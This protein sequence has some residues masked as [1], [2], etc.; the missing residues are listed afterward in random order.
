MASTP[1]ATR[2][3][4]FYLR[5]R[6]LR[7]C[8]LVLPPPLLL[9]Y[10]PNACVLLVLGPIIAIGFL[11]ATFVFFVVLFGILQLFEVFYIF[12]NLLKSWNIC[13]FWVSINFGRT[14]DRRV[15]TSFATHVIQIS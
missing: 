11:I 8:F 10:V 6:D 7:A 2:V 4:M 1:N 12:Q 9:A 3:F 15:Y 5:A 14:K 13:M